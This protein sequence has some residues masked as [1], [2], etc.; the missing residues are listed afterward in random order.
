MN[1]VERPP[2]S[3]AKRADREAHPHSRPHASRT[4]VVALVVLGGFSKALLFIS[5]IRHPVTVLVLAGAIGV[6]SLLRGRPASAAVAGAVLVPVAISPGPVL[7]G[8]ALGVATLI[9][10]MALFLAIGTLLRMPGQPSSRARSPHNTATG[11]AV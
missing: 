1:E 4:A 3:V 9:V 7:L 10:L 6:A 8:I 2:V 11:A 5:L